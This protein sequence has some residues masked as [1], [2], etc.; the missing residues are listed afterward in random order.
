MSTLAGRVALA[1][2]TA[3]VHEATGSRPEGRERQGGERQGNEAREP[4]VAERTQ[5]EPWSSDWQRGA[6]RLS[7]RRRWDERRS[8]ST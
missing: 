1:V 7:R 3:T 4:V 2:W 8:V 6:K 5:T